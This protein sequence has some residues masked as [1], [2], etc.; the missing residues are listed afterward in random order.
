M[1]QRGVIFDLFGTL[2]DFLPYDEEQLTS[3]KPMSV[4]VNELLTR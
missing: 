1:M 3:N 2:V 4:R